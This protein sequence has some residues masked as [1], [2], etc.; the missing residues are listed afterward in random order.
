MKRIDWMATLKRAGK[1]IVTSSTR[2]IGLKALSV[3]FALILWSYVITADPNITRDK[4][5]SGIGISVSGQSVLTSRG[6]AMLTDLDDVVSSVRVRVTVP[7]ASYSLVSESNV[8]VEIDM[9][10]IRATGK[11][12]LTLSGTSVY[13]EVAQ[14]WPEYI[15]IEVEALD[16]RYI[17]VNVELVGDD[18][19]KFWYSTKANPA[20]ITVS[21]PTSIVR[22][23]S[24]AIVTLD[25]TDI[26]SPTSRAEQFVLVNSQDE[27]IDAELTRSTSSVTVALEAYPAK[28]VAV[29]AEPDDLLSGNVPTGYEITSVTVSPE[30]VVIAGEGSLLDTISELS[31]EKIYVGNRTNS[32]TARANLTSLNGIKSLSTDQVTVNVMIEEIN[33]ARRFLDIPVSLVN[34]SDG[35]AVSSGEIDEVSVVVTG[36]YSK[37]ETLS[38]DDIIATVDVTGLEAGEYELPVYV[39]VDNQPSLSCTAT[40]A[41][42]TVA[43]K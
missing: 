23:V 2:N 40:P 43:I 31:T 29:S 36:P 5:L 15:D 35:Q 28:T 10:N 3:I 26:N 4:T 1:A 41:T 34:Q 6:L 17:P 38:G 13:G 19:S 11:Q 8:R 42:V 18:T 39:T 25:V 33:T 27:P 22:Q 24:S 14:I 37:M 16:Q 12:R 9:T 20:Q 7:Q 30:T 32:F 21:G